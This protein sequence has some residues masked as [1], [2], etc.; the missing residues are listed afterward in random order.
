M[1]RF[2]FVRHAD[3]Q[4]I[5]LH[6]SAG[7][8]PSLRLVRRSVS[9]RNSRDLDFARQLSQNLDPAIN[10]FIGRR[11]GDADVRVVATKNLAGDD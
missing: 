11:V 3:P 5:A 1:S 4:S 7:A 2:F 6:G 10:R 8:S 9:D